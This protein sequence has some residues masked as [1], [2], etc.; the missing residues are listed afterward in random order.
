MAN[1]GPE[2]GD[3]DAPAE[4]PATGTPHAGP[5]RRFGAI[6]SLA[7]VPWTVISIYSEWTLVFPFGFFNTSP[8]QLV[9]LYTMLF[10]AGGGLPRN[11]GLL[12][13]SVLFYLLA[14]GS[15][16]VALGDREDPR[17]TAGLLVLAGVA[18]LGVAYSVSHRL[19]YTPVPFG[20]LLMLVVAWW[21]YWPSLRATV[22]A[23]VE[24]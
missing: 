2:G 17:L 1:Q 3:G 5:R 19:Y 14:L 10:V 18:H 4:P 15:A 20:A 8:P 24:G 16:A 13:L 12:P 7:F 9:D 6:L 23:P 21:Y 22:M 11:P